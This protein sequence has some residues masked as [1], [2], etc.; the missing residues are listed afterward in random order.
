VTWEGASFEHAAFPLTAHNGAGQWCKKHKG[1]VHYFGTL[2]DWQSALGEYERT[3][4]FII[5]GRTPPA[6]AG[7]SLTVAELCD[8][9]LNAKLDALHAGEITNRTFAEYHKADRIVGV[10]LSDP[11]R[12]TQGTSERSGRMRRGPRHSNESSAPDGVQVCIR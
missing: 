6:A 10:W 7:D 4:P 11:L 12:A 3:W 9:F 1:H 5:T 8:A 2:S